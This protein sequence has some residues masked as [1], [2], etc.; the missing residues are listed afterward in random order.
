MNVIVARFR[1]AKP[2]QYTDGL[3]TG[4]IE[5]PYGGRPVVVNRLRSVGAQPVAD[6]GL[7]HD[8]PRLARVVFELLAQAGHVH[9]QTAHGVLVAGAEHGAQQLAVGHDAAGV[10]DQIAQQ[11]VLGWRQMDLLAASGDQPPP[12]VDLDVA[13]AHHARLSRSLVSETWRRATRIRASS[14]VMLN[15]LVT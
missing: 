2:A 5:R 8:Q 15:G 7:G 14:S 13:G 9:A 4:V 1:P 12:Q 3:S 6:A 11:A 10:S